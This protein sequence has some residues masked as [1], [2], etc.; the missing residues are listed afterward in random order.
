MMNPT[1]SELDAEDIVVPET[2]RKKV[3]A[4]HRYYLRPELDGNR[5]VKTVSEKKQRTIILQ[6]MLLL[7]RNPEFRDLTIGS[8]KWFKLLDAQSVAGKKRML[9]WASGSLIY[10]G[11]LRPMELKVLSD[12]HK[13]LIESTYEVA[14]LTFAELNCLMFDSIEQGICWIYVQKLPLGVVEGLNDTLSHFKWPLRFKA[15]L[16]DT[17]GRCYPKV[18][19]SQ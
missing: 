4:G 11:E 8:V 9:D 1:P 7:K 10:V 6:K 13:P 14:K 17:Q 18:G 3:P 2:I 5:K 16:K 19:Y 15:E 12:M